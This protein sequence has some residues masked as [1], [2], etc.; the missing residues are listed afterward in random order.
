MANEL[1]VDSTEP[2]LHMQI[3]IRGC[4]KLGWIQNDEIR[5]EL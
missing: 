2:P 3:Y 5:K 4:S 1:T